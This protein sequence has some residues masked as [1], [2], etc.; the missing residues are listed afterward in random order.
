MCRLLIVTSCLGETE[1]SCSGLSD[2]DPRYK[3]LQLA[4]TLW[5]NHVK[6]PPARRLPEFHTQLFGQPH[7]LLTRPVQ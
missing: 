5:T 4:C 7:Q 1:E 6:R 3:A 2:C